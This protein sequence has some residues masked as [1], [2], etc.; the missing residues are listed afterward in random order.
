M[1]QQQNQNPWLLKSLNFELKFSRFKVDVFKILEPQI[2]YIERKYGS[3]CISVLEEKEV[4]EADLRLYNFIGE[5]LDLQQKEQYK[6][7]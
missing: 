3:F 7:G 6:N 5:L 4:S 1:A 2:N